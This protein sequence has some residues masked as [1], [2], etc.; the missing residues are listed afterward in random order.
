MRFKLFKGLRDRFDRLFGR[1]VVDEQ[2]FEELEETLL[3]ADVGVTPTAELIAKM[4]ARVRADRIEDPETIRSELSALIRA[5]LEDEAGELTTAG[6]RPLVYLILGV[7]GA[8]KTTTIGKLASYFARQGKTVLVAAADTFR[9]AA[10]EQLEIWAR[11]SGADIVKGVQGGDSSAVVFD[12]ISAARARGADIVLVD[13]AGRQHTRSNLMSELDKVTRVLTK[14]LGRPADEVLLV[15]DGHT[16]QNAIRQATEFSQVAGV[17]GV[18]VTKL[19][20]TS[21]G[22]AVLGIKSE[23]GLPVKLIGVGEDVDDLRPFSASEYAEA[24]LS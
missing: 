4:R 1:G 10:V 22:G 9:A 3:S 12:A 17:T 23:L 18:V 11:R 2:L 16:G 20:G 5:Q 6:P 7:N 15:I 14:A 19:D 13:T 24:L 21:R 8:G